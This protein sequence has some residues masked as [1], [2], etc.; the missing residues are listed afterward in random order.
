MGEA[1]LLESQEEGNPSSTI[2]PLL[3]LCYNRHYESKKNYFI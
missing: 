1:F 2:V 3:I